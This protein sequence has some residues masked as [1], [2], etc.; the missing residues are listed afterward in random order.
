MCKW[1]REQWFNTKLHSD[2][3]EREE[4]SEVEEKIQQTK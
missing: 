1:R 2:E 4:E 3:R